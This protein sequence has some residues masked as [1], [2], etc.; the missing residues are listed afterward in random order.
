ML[1][2]ITATIRILILYQHHARLNNN[3]I[4]CIAPII[5]FN[6]LHVKFIYSYLFIYPFLL[7]PLEDSDL[8]S[9]FVGGF[10]F[11]DNL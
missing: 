1:K 3:I 5:S 10:M 2:F 6:I 8:M 4:L 9:K 11:V 7:T